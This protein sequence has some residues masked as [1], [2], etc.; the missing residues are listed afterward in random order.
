MPQVNVSVNEL[1]GSGGV[2]TGTGAAFIAGPTD[3]GPPVGGPLYVKC[4]Q[5]SDYVTAFGPRSATSATMYDWLDEFFHDGGGSAVAYVTRETDNTATSASLQLQDSGPEPTIK[6]T[7]L[8]PGTDGNNIYIV[9]AVSGG[10]FTIDVEDSAG[11]ILESWGPYST[12]AALYAANVAS[13]YVSFAQSTATGHTTNNPAALTAT[14]LS[15]GADA[16]DLTDAKAVAALANFPPTLGPGTVALPGVTSS[17]GWTGLMAHAQ[18]NN[19]FYVLDTPDSTSAATVISNFSTTGAAS[20]ASYG[21]AVQGSL[22]LPG[23]TPG[24]T[25]TVPGSAAVAALRSQVASTPNQNTA[26][27]GPT[28]PLTYPQGF[29]TYFGSAVGPTLAAPCFSQTD[30]NSLTN[31]GICFFANWYDT[32]CLF[33][34]VTPVSKTIDLTYW[35]ASASCERMNLVYLGQRIMATYLFQTNDAANNLINKVTNDLN[36]M[37]RSEY[38][39]GAI[40]YP[41]DSFE[42]AFAV[43]V[44]API[45]T[46]LTEGA[47]Q[48]NANI[49]VHI[50]PFVDIANES[51]TT[52]PGTVAVS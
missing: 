13:Q 18:A 49:Q 16:S 42:E 23:I 11:D 41:Q 40:G 9:V 51:I 1:A 50:G 12:T 26:P 2:P 35:Q 15:G 37:G 30:I 28:W 17:T 3:Q 39:A 46:P 43:N 32:L 4:S 44:A 47:G 7:A 14:A 21:L 8:T 33:E 22:I 19:R 10:S 45:N 20:N 27:A 6:V 52:V 5:L 38:N 34:F 31:A 48:L 24:T 25:R 29:T 36:G